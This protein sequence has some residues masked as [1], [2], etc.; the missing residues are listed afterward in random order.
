MIRLP[1]GAARPRGWVAAFMT[2]DFEKGFVGWLDKLAPDLFSDDLYGQHRLTSATPSKDLGAISGQDVE[3]SAQFAWWNS[4]T[5]SNWRDGW[6]RH[7]LLVGGGKGKMLAKAWVNRILATQDAGYLGIYAP[8]LR[9]KHRGENGELWAQ[10]TLFRAL[11]GYYEVTGESRVLEAVRRAVDATLGL[12]LVPGFNPFD[13]PGGYSGNAHGLMFVDVLDSLATLTGD[14]RYPAAA[15]ALYE[16]YCQASV[17]EPDVQRQNLLDPE[18]RF[19]GHGVHTWEHLRALTL[20][21]Y[22]SGR[23]DDRA[24][25]EAFLSRLESLMTP[26]GGPVGDEW[27]EGRSADADETGYE[28]CSLV[29][30][31]DSYA[32]LLRLTGD[33]RWA[34]RMEHLAFNAALGAR[35][36]QEPSLAYL[37]TD[38]CFSLTGVKN[39]DQPEAGQTRYR[40]SPVHREAAVCCVPNAGRLWP[41]YLRSQAFADADGLRV[42]LYGPASVKT[43]V[44]GVPLELELDTAYPDS[45]TV[46][47]RLYPETSVEFT[48]FLRLPSWSEGCLVTGG[49]ASGGTLSEDDGWLELRKVWGR[50]DTLTVAFEAQVQTHTTAGGDVWFSR[51]PLVWALPLA[52]RA[53]VTRTWDL[54]EFREWAHYPGEDPDWGLAPGRE[55]QAVWSGEAVEVPLVGPD[56]QEVLRRLVPVKQTLLRRVTF[57]RKEIP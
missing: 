17:S 22:Y 39:L 46:E 3:N 12:W 41:S 47:V 44:A 4:E 7:A 37:K 18:Y 29:E 53:E 21:A 33:P 15:V 34:D 24:A 10:T 57:P 40:C 26:T 13:Q 28:Y 25:L 16:A 54:G 1:Q 30:L 56:G 23:A 35:H 49:G 52:D 36:P 55:T 51:G 38:N 42:L 6:V 9:W 45:L 2:R 32:L 14:P 27:I 20:A 11:L 31:F 48:L 5:Q 43:V 8:D 50:G 19:Q